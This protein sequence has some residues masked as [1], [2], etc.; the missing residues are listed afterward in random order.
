MAC[1]HHWLSTRAL[2]VYNV[3]LRAGKSLTADEIDAALRS[4]WSP[5]MASDYVAHGVS[6]LLAKGFV[7]QASGL[8]SS[9]RPGRRLQRVND[10]I[11]LA[12]V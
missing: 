4:S 1:E 12:W 3:L 11:D 5:E 9:A 8:I 10:N 7:T 2:S 6:Y